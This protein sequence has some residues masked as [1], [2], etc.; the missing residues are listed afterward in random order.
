LSNKAIIGICLVRNDDRF[1][2]Q[3]L[4]NVCEFCDRLIIADHQSKDDTAAIA[5][6]WASE[7]EHIEYHLI[8]HPS[9]SHE[10]I[11]PYCQQDVWMFA[12]DGDELY[13]KDRLAA[14]R[15][16]LM[17]GRFSDKWQILGK[18]LHCDEYRE[19]EG[20]A[21]GYLARPSRSMTKLYN[22]S[23]I[24][25]W[26]GPCSERLHHGEIVFKPRSEGGTK[27]S[28]ESECSWEDAVFRC[29]HMVFIK[30]SSLQSEGDVSR[31]NI[32]EINHFSKLRKLIFYV[33]RFFGKEPKSKTKHITYMRGERVC[34]DVRAFFSR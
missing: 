18:A 4:H 7:N 20:K 11:R 5:Q 2:D 8:A 10:L 12:V 34:K 29:L 19:N 21:M 32:A 24:D 14:F 22:F 17:A 33:M 31:P 25:D 15:E 28:S 1:L 26:K 23:H 30:R 27:D 16:Q 3:I 13:E 6:K 9:E